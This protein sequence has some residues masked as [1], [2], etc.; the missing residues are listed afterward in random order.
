MDEFNDTNALDHVYDKLANMG[1]SLYKNWLSA[2]QGKRDTN[3][4]TWQR[5]VTRYM[6]PTQ[7]VHHGGRDPPLILPDALLLPLYE[8]RLTMAVK[9][10]GLGSLLSWNV[11]KQFMGTLVDIKPDLLEKIRQ[12]R[13]CFYPSNG[14]GLT[15]DDLGQLASSRLAL[16]AYKTAVPS[17]PGGDDRLF[18]FPS[19]TAIGTFFMAFC[20][21]H[22]VPLDAAGETT[23]GN[24]RSVCNTMVRNMDTFA[25][26][27]NCTRNSAMNPVYKCDFL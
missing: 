25:E 23:A 19:V 7:S 3:T 12:R 16:R 9:Y 18:G 24:G 20:Y 6:E 13:K 27:F 15:A 4:E 26:V 21:L 11:A 5:V 17:G 2:M 1:D 14:T 10:G 22:C 8:E